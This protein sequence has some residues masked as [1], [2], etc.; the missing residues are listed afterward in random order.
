[1]PVNDHPGFISSIVCTDKPALFA[2]EKTTHM[3]FCWK[4]LTLLLFSL[5]VHQA[6]GQDVQLSAKVDTSHFLIGDQITLELNAQ[7]PA[8]THFAWPILGDTV[9]AQI[10]VVDKMPVDTILTK[11]QLQLHQSLTLTVFDS[12]YHVLPPLVIHYGDSLLQQAQSA[13]LLLMVETV[14]VD[15]TQAIKPLKA[16]LAAPYT[17]REIAP[18]VLGG[19][20]ALAVILFL[21]WYYIR[22]RKKQPFIPVRHKPLIP[23]HTEAL[24]ELSKIRAAQLWQNGKLKTY[25]TQVTDVLRHYLYRQFGIQAAELTTYEILD[26]VKKQ[27]IERLQ[28]NQLH[29]ILE[30]ADMVKFAKSIPPANEN[31]KSLDLAEAFVKQSTPIAS[32]ETETKQTPIQSTQE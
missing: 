21:I 30:R 23:A 28:I 9:T 6:L 11:E 15:T 25:H 1:M 12:G 22:S 27:P 18:W 19:L 7:L 17:F 13:P 4:I 24:Q 31:E 29:E 26:L 14:E 10:E 20:S 2:V 32:S 8:G 16:P 5:T 3:K